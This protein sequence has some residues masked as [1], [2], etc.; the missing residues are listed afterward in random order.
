MRTIS[1]HALCF[2]SS[3]KL[4]GQSQPWQSQPHASRFGQGD[5]HILEKVLDK[6]AGVK[7]AGNHARAEV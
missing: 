6:K 1:A 4:F 3:I 7:I 2:H 5:A